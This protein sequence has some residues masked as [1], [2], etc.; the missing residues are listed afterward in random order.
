[1]IEEKHK[2]YEGY[3]VMTAIG[4][5]AAFSHKY[6]EADGIRTAYLEA[7]EGDPLVLIHGG[8][9]GADSLGNWAATLHDFARHF[10]VFA[11]DMVGFGRTEKPD[12]KAYKYDQ[13]SRDRHMIAVIET[14][15]I[16]PAHIIGN[17]MG[18]LTGMG[19]AVTRPDLVKGLVLMGSA[20]I[21][22]PLNDS[23]KSI[24]NYDFTRDGM[25]RIMKAL[26]NDDFVIDENMLDY[27]HRLTLEPENKAA[28]EAIQGWIRNRHG[29]YCDEHH[30]ASVRAPTL[31]VAGKQDKVVPVTSAY[32]IL[33]LIPQAWGVI[34]PSC[35]HWAMLE[36]PRRFVD[37]STDFLQNIPA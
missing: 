25:H 16:G 4:S 33:E 32:R 12:P 20:A 37:L 27:R 36:H 22:T 10:H 11:V 24:M 14:L 23:L 15:D 17:S 30:V 19:V 8:G 7:G 35:G 5:P 13:D 26:T 29:L 21:R 1:M 2:I 18:G 28:Y 31:V 34:F 9:A 6:V 3:I